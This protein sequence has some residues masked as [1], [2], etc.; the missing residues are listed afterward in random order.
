LSKPDYSKVV[1]P[2]IEKLF[3]DAKIE[4]PGDLRPVCFNGLEDEYLKHETS[5]AINAPLSEVWDA[6]KTIHPAKGWNS[7]MIRFAFMYSRSEDQY[8]YHTEDQFAGIAKGQ[9]YLVNLNII[10]SVQIAVA[11][12]V[13]E[14]NDQEKLIKLCYL[15]TGKTEGSQ[16]IQMH[17]DGENKTIIIHKTRYKGT[18]FIRDRLLYPFF[19]QKAMNQFH[20]KMGDL[21]M[22]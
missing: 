8:V 3:R 18:S 9:V 14:V 20:Q 6:Y 7:K 22:K 21:I 12:E 19:H 2:S 10:K 4:G 16:W 11:H 1:Y 15:N 5:Y 13:D 17:A